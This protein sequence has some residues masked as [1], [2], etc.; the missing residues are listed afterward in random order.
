M[1]RQSAIPTGVGLVFIDE[2]INS[3]SALPGVFFDAAAFITAAAAMDG[4]ASM[5]GA[6][7]LVISGAAYMD[8]VAAVQAI[9]AIEAE[10]PRRGRA[11]ILMVSANAFPEHVEAGEHA[12]A[13]GHLAKPFTADA[14]IRAVREGARPDA[15]PTRERRAAG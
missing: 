5:A 10:D 3:A 4:V 13:D 14:L 7:S 15:A 1:A 8:G 12:G 9:R 2:E 11:R 6:G